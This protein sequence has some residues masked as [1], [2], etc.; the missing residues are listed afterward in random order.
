MLSGLYLTAHLYPANPKCGV[1]ADTPLWSCSVKKTTALIIYGYQGKVNK[2][3]TDITFLPFCTK[4]L[5]LAVCSKR[6][7]FNKKALPDGR[8]LNVFCLCFDYT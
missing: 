4:G 5:V 2:R 1:N 8:A 3:F 7:S 6:F